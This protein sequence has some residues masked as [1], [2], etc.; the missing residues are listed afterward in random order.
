MKTQGEDASWPEN[1]ETA[2]INFYLQALFTYSI[3]ISTKEKK[4]A[5]NLSPSGHSH[6]ALLFTN[7]EQKRVAAS[8][9]L[10]VENAV[11]CQS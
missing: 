6:V 5:L 4:I 8:R 7:D 9:T 11:K 10:T 1:V 3:N 2:S